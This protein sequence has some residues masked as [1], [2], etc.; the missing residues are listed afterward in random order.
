MCYLS[1][2]L[3]IEKYIENLMSS[4]QIV[5]KKGYLKQRT[6]E[7][8]GSFKPLYRRLKD[9]EYHGDGIL[10]VSLPTMIPS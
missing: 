5:V 3:F 6:I 4:S 7:I 2:Y 8:T 10:V 1:I 9:R